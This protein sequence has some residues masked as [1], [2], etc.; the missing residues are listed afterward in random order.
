M[1]T[2][3]VS[4]EHDHLVELSYQIG[5]ELFVP[6][7]FVG[8]LLEMI[9]TVPGPKYTLLI[10]HRPA[11]AGGIARL[12]GGVG[13]AWVMMG[14]LGRKHFVTTHRAIR[15]QFNN[16]SEPYYPGFSLPEFHRVQA[17]IPEDFPVGM[18]F[19]ESFG[20]KCEAVLQQYG[21]DRT[22]FYLYA[23]VR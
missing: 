20:L 23:K 4:C 21:P 8:N 3:I 6:E 10:D 22:D 14:D 16:L 5:R 13:E 12:W 18:R 11:A 2:E 19:A 9:K 15:K 1:K 17:A 7:G